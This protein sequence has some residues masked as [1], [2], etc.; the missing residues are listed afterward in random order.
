MLDWTLNPFGVP[1]GAYTVL[2]IGLLLILIGSV[3]AA[4]V[5]VF[6]LRK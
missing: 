6:I 5:K 4:I 3:I 2:W 1:L